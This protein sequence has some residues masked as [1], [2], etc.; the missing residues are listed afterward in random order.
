MLGY[1]IRYLLDTVFEF[2]LDVTIKYCN[3]E[4]SSVINF[5]WFCH[6]VF[7]PKP[8]TCPVERQMS[9]RLINN[10]HFN[11][12]DDGFCNITLFLFWRKF[13]NEMYTTVFVSNATKIQFIILQMTRV[14]YYCIRLTW[15]LIWLV[16]IMYIQ[17]H[18]TCMYLVLLT[19]AHTFLSGNCLMEFLTFT[20]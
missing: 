14:S 2:I 12:L 4:G 17:V 16:K 18:V 19:N 9:Y 8:F 3:L 20:Y 1:S 6:K 10:F 15:I 13:V 7:L 5:L 11:I